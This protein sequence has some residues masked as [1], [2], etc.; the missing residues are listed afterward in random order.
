MKP[1]V[2]PPKYLGDGVYISAPT[3]DDVV[4]TTGH[5]NPARA[6]NVIWFTPLMA[7]SLRKWLDQY[8]VSVEG[9]H[10]Q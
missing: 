6:V 7:G 3:A 2:P 9:G 1:S 5:D 8:I 4:I 10:D